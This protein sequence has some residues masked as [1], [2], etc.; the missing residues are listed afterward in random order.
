MRFFVYIV[1]FSI[2]FKIE[3][4]VTYSFDVFVG[5]GLIDNEGV[6]STQFYKELP[7]LSGSVGSNVSYF[8]KK[9]D[10]LYV[11]TGLNLSQ[12]VGQFK[13]T[14]EYYSL[15]NITAI[16]DMRTYASNVLLGVPLVVG[17]QANNFS[18]ETGLETTYNLRYKYKRTYT[19][20]Y[21]DISRFII[22]ESTE[23]LLHK[24][25]LS[26]TTSFGY[27]VSDNVSFRMKINVG[28]TEYYKL[29]RP[30]LEPDFKS[31]IHCIFF[32]LRY[33]M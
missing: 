24:V 22:E 31:R 29:E 20:T 7:G 11:S 30:S 9:H 2:C 4:Q 33:S 28:L 6:S 18:L 15:Y 16:R 1:L 3:A 23:G 17:Y 5:A 21:R 8:S 10:G 25:I 13:L 26:S 27:K 32:G 14:D 19:E 12:V